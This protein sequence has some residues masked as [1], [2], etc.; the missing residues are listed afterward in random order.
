MFARSA[1]DGC[2]N[3]LRDAHDGVRDAARLTA[4]LVTLESIVDV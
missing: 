1:L 3:V 4:F 2:T